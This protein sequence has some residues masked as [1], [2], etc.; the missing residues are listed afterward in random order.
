MEKTPW[1]GRNDDQGQKRILGLM[2][3]A[4]RFRRKIRRRAGFT[5]RSRIRF[6]GVAPDVAIPMSLA[7]SIATPKI[8]KS[9]LA[10]GFR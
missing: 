10:S 7:L 1:H 6:S 9:D 8:S 5:A 4:C 3:R 2:A